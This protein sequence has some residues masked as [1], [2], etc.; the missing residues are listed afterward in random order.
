L[1]DSIRKA[2]AKI[3]LPSDIYVSPT[4][5]KQAAS[6][7]K[8]STKRSKRSGDDDDDFPARASAEADPHSCAAEEEAPSSIAPQTSRSSANTRVMATGATSM[9]PAKR[10]KPN[11]STV[12]PSANEPATPVPP[13][14]MID[15]TLSNGSDT[16]V[17]QLVQA[18]ARLE[19][20]LERALAGPQQAQATATISEEKPLAAT[21]KDRTQAKVAARTSP[22]ARQEQEEDFDE[23]EATTPSRPA[24]RGPKGG[25]SIIR[26]NE[27]LMTFLQN[28]RL[29]RLQDEEHIRRREEESER[30]RAASNARSEKLVYDLAW[31]SEGK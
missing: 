10:A 6:R 13:P 18:V 25:A 4:T 30:H 12:S 8:K 2:S 15:P 26:R 24:A 22:V 1:Q 21:P 29:A 16:G 28:E 27:L 11:P 19:Q 3:R 9:P 23:E 14:A 20:L 31:Y 17:G 5:P 7:K